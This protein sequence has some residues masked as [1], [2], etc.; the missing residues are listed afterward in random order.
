MPVI[1]LNQNRSRYRFV[2]R[3]KSCFGCFSSRWTN[4]G[5]VKY[6]ER[7]LQAR[8]PPGRAIQSGCNRTGNSIWPVWY[9]LYR[10]RQNFMVVVMAYVCL[11]ISAKFITSSGAMNSDIRYHTSFGY[12]LYTCASLAASSANCFNFRF[13]IF[14]ATTA[15]SSSSS[16]SSC[17]GITLIEL[18][19]FLRIRF[20]FEL[21]NS[22]I[23]TS[24]AEK[25]KLLFASNPTAMRMAW[26]DA[27]AVKC[28]HQYSFAGIATLR[29][30][31][32]FSG[33]STVKSMWLNCVIKRIMKW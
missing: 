31:S 3:W 16:S 12:V 24:E 27:I 4:G 15:S 28:T 8:I 33:G 7:I 30:V 29:N 14:F 1:W 5:Y 21:A 26:H 9:R 13:A 25:V 17:S 20:P 6:S 23:V 10:V 19:F 11:Q 18:T 32:A 22:L 2:N